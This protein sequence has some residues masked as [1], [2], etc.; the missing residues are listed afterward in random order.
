MPSDTS[1]REV[2]N[3]LV[4][5]FLDVEGKGREL[6]GGM[7]RWCRDLARLLV[8]Q[9]FLVRIFQK[10]NVDFNIHYEQFIQVV[11]IKSSLRSYGCL[12]FA[13]RIRKYVK[14]SD[15]VIAVSQ[16]VAMIGRYDNAI[17]INHG[18]WWH[19]D[20]GYLKLAFNKHIQK[21]L[22]NKFNATICVDTNYIN[23][24]HAEI[25]NRSAWASKLLYVPNYSVEYR[26]GTATSE[27]KRIILFPRRMMGKS[28]ENDPRG[29]YLFLQAAKQL[30]DKG[31]YNDLEFW[32]VGRSDMQDIITLWAE[33]NGLSEK[34]T[35]FEA[36]FDEMPAV[37]QQA[38]VV[39]V[40]TMA[41]E[42]TSLSAIEAMIAGKPVI[43]THIGGLANIVINAVNGYVAD[44][45]VHSLVNCIEEAL[46]FNPMSQEQIWNA[47]TASLGKKRWDKK[48]ID[49][50]SKF[51]KIP[52]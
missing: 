22:I 42:G 14:A 3:I 33:A 34:L 9:G 32:M 49:C 6:T 43:V 30:L 13:T 52:D 5:W 41:N 25:R 37:Y 24:C 27:R 29:S 45:S 47:V 2:I 8:D 36:K 4:L 28:I 38:A 51:I 39:V 21:H 15:P 48:I 26:T 46:R 20:M 44:L 17:A 35:L 16:E 12:S 7:E 23:W 18:I 40:P 19:S 1:R 10:A 50:V 31:V 11:G